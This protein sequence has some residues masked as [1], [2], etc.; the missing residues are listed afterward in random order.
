MLLKTL[1]YGVPE[2]DDGDGGDVSIFIQ[3][4]VSAIA[5]VVGVT[6]TQ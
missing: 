3:R 4:N 6:L 5:V 2:K 1:A